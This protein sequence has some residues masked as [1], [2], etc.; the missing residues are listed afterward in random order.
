MHAQHSAFVNRVSGAAGKT[1]HNGK[2]NLFGVFLP[3]VRVP[4]S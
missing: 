2:A 4:K 1:I 3:I